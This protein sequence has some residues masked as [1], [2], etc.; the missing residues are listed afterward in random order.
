MM[1]DINLINGERAG[2]S[3]LHAYQQRD[4]IEFA[5]RKVLIFEPFLVQ[6]VL[7]QRALLSGST[8]QAIS[9]ANRLLSGP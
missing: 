9:R 5:S 2:N 8:T 6:K 3:Q 7:G 4:A 1:H